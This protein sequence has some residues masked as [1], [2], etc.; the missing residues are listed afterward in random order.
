MA[1]TPILILC[2]VV[3]LVAAYGVFQDFQSLWYAYKY[4]L[5]DE[6][7]YLVRRLFYAAESMMFFVFAVVLILYNKK[8][9]KSI[10]IVLLG[11][12]YL[13]SVLPQILSWVFSWFVQSFSFRAILSIVLTFFSFELVLIYGL[14]KNKQTEKLAG[15]LLALNIL[16]SIISFFLNHA[17]ATSYAV[18]YF[19]D[20]SILNPSL[21]FCILLF[22]FPILSRAVLKKKETHSP[23]VSSVS[24]S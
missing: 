15:G 5:Y 11:A 4:S 22:V 19:L 3:C 7:S 20:I 8:S 21:W 17:E 6:G 12:S 13:S 1:K 9:R 24:E 16:V 18:R 14:I 23:L 2:G 10:L